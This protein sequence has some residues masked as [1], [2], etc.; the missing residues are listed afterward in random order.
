MIR[1]L[2]ETKIFI[3]HNNSPRVIDDFNFVLGIP[4]VRKFGWVESIIN[5]IGV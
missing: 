5:I 2:K 4:H 3:L 1:V